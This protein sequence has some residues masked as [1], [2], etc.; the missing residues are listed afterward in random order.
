LRL[1]EGAGKKGESRHSLDGRGNPAVKELSSPRS[2]GVKRR[3]QLRKDELGLHILHRL[4]KGVGRIGENG[5]FEVG[6]WDLEE[7][8]ASHHRCFAEKPKG[9]TQVRKKGRSFREKKKWDV[10]V[11]FNSGKRKQHG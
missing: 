4:K 9:N 3:E 7:R 5:R 11:R 10:K 8:K 1:H 2:V 6:T